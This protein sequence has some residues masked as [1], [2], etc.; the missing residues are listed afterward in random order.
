MRFVYPPAQIISDRRSP[1]EIARRRI[2]TDKEVFISLL[3][4]ADFADERR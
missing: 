3:I 4:T 2:R 1:G